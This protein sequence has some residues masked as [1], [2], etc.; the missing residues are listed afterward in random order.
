M[1]RR[2]AFVSAGLIIWYASRPDR[3]A[4]GSLGLPVHAGQIAASQKHDAARAVGH[5]VVV[6][7]CAA[8][9]RE[10]NSAGAGAS[11]TTWCPLLD[12][13]RTA[14]DGSNDD[15]KI[16]FRHQLRLSSSRHCE[17][18]KAF[19]SVEVGNGSRAFKP[20]SVP[21]IPDS[22]PPSATCISATRHTHA[23]PSLGPER[24]Q[25]IG[26]GDERQ[27]RQ[28]PD[29]GQRNLPGHAVRKHAS[30]AGRQPVRRGETARSSR[31][32][33]WSG[34]RRSVPASHHN[35]TRLVAG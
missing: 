6:R 32:S 29:Q 24:H 15:R 20:C 9:A 18:A 19:T 22:G 1:Q 5:V 21:A 35:S 8:G 13:K 11:M 27:Y 4:L 14:G 2:A 26:Q 30:R 16:E 7:A 33:T 34:L 3:G 28:Q 12:P 10:A 23:W 25:R 31:T 17:S